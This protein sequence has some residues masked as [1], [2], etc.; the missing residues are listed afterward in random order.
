MPIGLLYRNRDAVRYDLATAEG[1]DM[2]ASDKLAALDRELGR[3]ER[4]RPIVVEHYL[5]LFGRAL[6]IEFQDTYKRY[7]HMG[8]PDRILEEASPCMAANGVDPEKAR[9]LVVKTFGS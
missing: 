7:M 3:F 4:E 1:L 2:S 5:T 8:D 9:G 6:G